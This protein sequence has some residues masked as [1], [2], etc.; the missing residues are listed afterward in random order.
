MSLAQLNSK[1]YNFQRFR[2]AKDY[3]KV[4]VGGYE[5]LITPWFWGVI[6]W[7]RAGFQSERLVS[8]WAA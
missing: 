8:K 1:H 3:T 4:G 5:L 7:F 2:V 6:I